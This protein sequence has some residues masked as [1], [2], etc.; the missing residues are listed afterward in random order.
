MRRRY[1]EPVLPDH[2][3]YG[4]QILHLGEHEVQVLYTPGHSP[5]SVSFYFADS[6]FCVSGD[7]IF[8]GSAGRFDLPGASAPQL[9]ASL[10]LL[11]DLP[12]QTR[13]LPGHSNATTV[14][15]EKLTN[16]ACLYPA[17][18]FG[19]A[20][21][22]ITRFIG[23]GFAFNKSSPNSDFASRSTSSTAKKQA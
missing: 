23:S 6:E 11:T 12:A 10:R 7:V 15:Q 1:T 18:F 17:S 9:A 13:L 21:A 4:G 22:V 2:F 8:A 16:P 3:L 14:S 5:G 20:L 19:T